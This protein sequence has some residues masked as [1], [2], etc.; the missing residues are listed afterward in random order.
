MILAIKLLKAAD[1]VKDQTFFLAQISQQA[2]KKTLFPIGHLRKDQVR[3]IAIE[4]NL[5]KIA[6][7]KEV[8]FRSFFFF[9]NLFLTRLGFLLNSL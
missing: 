8:S 1:A 7:K 9:L 3:Q 6:K 5:Q 2:L 4:E